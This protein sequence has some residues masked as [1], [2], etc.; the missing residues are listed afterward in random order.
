MRLKNSLVYLG[1]AGLAA[2]SGCG[3]NPPVVG[4]IT[5]SPASPSTGQTVAASASVTDGDTAA[6]CGFSTSRMVSSSSGR[7]VGR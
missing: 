5:P 6:A 4:A 3:S 1:L 2:L 7:Q